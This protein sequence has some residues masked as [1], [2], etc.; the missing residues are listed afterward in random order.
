MKI[1]DADILE[2]VSGLDTLDLGM[3]GDASFS[4]ILRDWGEISHIEATPIAD[5]LT[6]DGHDIRIK[7]EITLHY[8]DGGELERTISILASDEYD[9]FGL[10]NITVEAAEQAA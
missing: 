2:N 8:A 6:R 5:T 3:A 1:S 10:R 4:K 7:A 9:I